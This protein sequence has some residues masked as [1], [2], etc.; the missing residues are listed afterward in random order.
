MKMTKRIVALALVAFMLVAS[1]VFASATAWVTVTSSGTYNVV[2]GVKYQSYSVY[3]SDSGHTETMHTLQFHPDDGYIA[4]PYT[5]YAG[6]TSTVNNQFNAA[7]ADGYEVVAAINGA[8]FDMTSGTPYGTIA[9]NGTLNYSALWAGCAAGK[10]GTNGAND[11]LVTFGYDGSIELVHSWH[12]W[13]IFINGTLAVDGGNVNINRHHYP[14]GAA[15]DQWI[16]SQVYYYDESCGAYTDTES[17]YRGVEVICEKVG[18]TEMGFGAPLQ[19]KVVSVLTNSYQAPIGKNQFVLFALNGGSYYN[20]LAN[21]KTGDSVTVSTYNNVSGA[22]A[23]LDSKAGAMYHC[24]SLVKNGVDL[25]DTYNE[26]GDGHYVSTTYSQWTCYGTKADG[27]VV[28]MTTTG[29]DTGDTSAS[30]TLKDVASAMISIGCTNVYRCDGGGSVAMY[31]SNTGSGNAGWIQSSSRAVTDVLLIV[32][33]T[34]LADDEINAELSEKISAAKELV[35]D[36]PS[37]QTLIDEGEALLAAGAAV[38][39]VRPTLVALTTFVEE[40]TSLTGL[41]A[42]VESLDVTKYSEAVLSEVRSLYDTAVSLVAAGNTTGAQATKCFNDLKAALAREGEGDLNT[43]ALVPNKFNTS[44]GQNDCT[45]FT[46]AFGTVTAANANHNWTVNILLEWDAD[47]ECYIVKSAKTNEAWGDAGAQTPPSY[48]LT[49]GQLLI[50]V[51]GEL[52]ITN[53]A[54]AVQVKEGDEARIYGIDV[55]NADLGSLGYIRFGELAEVEPEP[56]VGIKGDVNGDGEIKAADYIALRRAVMG[57]FVLDEAAAKV[58]DVNGD[59]EI[60]AADYIALRR[61][62]M[63]TFVLE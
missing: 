4:I 62:V 36:V 22:N 20:A 26:I 25:T 1:C 17:G 47:K 11:E 8:F 63:G 59:G 61:A 55:D 5:Q 27:T 24:G 10:P 7:V 45:I 28:F 18:N 13:Q 60:K 56:P 41:I 35:K 53:R 2:D 32:K 49:D 57:T 46:P 16:S 29:G 54:M 12:D 50:A 42:R 44:I 21:L 58:A 14:A 31:V 37:A 30:L 9:S 39:E 43:I 33:K 15:A 52:D 51:H 19:G 48:T 23:I 40:N 6:N 3:G 34:S 38:G